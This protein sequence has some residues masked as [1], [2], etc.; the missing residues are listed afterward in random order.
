MK[1]KY[2]Q[3]YT[4]NGHRIQ[5]YGNTA[6][7]LADCMKK[8]ESKIDN[9]LDLAFGGMPFKEY[10]LFCVETYKPNQSEKARTD[11]LSAMRCHIFPEIG[12]MRV[13]VI[14]SKHCQIIM[15]RLAG[16]SKSL[17]NTV[18]QALKFVFGRA[19]ADNM[20]VKDPTAQLIRPRS[21]SNRR[22]A[23]TPEEREIVLKV[24][25][26]DRRYYG[27]L[28]ML[29]CGCRPSEAFECKGSDLSEIN[30]IPT[31]HIRGTKTAL[32][33]RFVPVPRYL[34]NLVKNTLKT[35]YIAQNRHGNK[36]ANQ[37]R[38]WRSFKRQM[39]IAMGC[40]LYRNEIVEDLVAPDLVPYCFRHEFCTE[41]ARK[42][43]D[44]RV[45]QKLMGHATIKMTAEIYT[46]LETADI[47]QRSR[48]LAD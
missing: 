24:A 19:M 11:Y 42:G 26:T 40:A 41:C 32:S 5:A 45:T 2:Y 35:D 34:S 21:T 15:N 10:A 27:Y 14:S 37:A 31:L 7:E 16:K 48:I 36:I 17:V 8:K 22:R 38:L 12:M 3:S 33:D 6:K 13:N 47:I 18:Y 39:N 43:I 28:L 29:L 1:Y 25:A 46:N 30:G 4:Y 9:K 44:V 20:I 23:L